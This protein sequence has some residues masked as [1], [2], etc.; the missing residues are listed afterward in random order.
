M[1]I[2][3]I[4]GSDKVPATKRQRKQPSNAGVGRGA[5][6]KKIKEAQGVQ[7]ASSGA[8]T[9]VQVERSSAPSGLPS[10]AQVSQKKRY[11]K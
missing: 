1:S 6:G 10:E 3:I 7:G 5:G 4:K 11:S 2:F 9:N 8:S